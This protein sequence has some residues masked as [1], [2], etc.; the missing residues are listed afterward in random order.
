MPTP[1]KQRTRISLEDKVKLIEDSKRPGFN[2]KDAMEKYGI[3]RNAVSTI[4]KDQAK[5]LKCLDSGSISKTAKSVRKSPLAE[6]ECKLYEFLTEKTRK[7]L[8]INGPLL[9]E[10]AKII[11]ERMKLTSDIPL[12]FEFS[13]GW[14]D[15]FKKRFNVKFKK[16]IGE[17]LSADDEA[18]DEWIKTQ[19]PILRNS[20][21]A[22]DIFNCD[23]CGV[24]FRGMAD[25]SFN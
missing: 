9:T 24:Y 22:K 2:R 20:Y 1:I 3:G 12:E 18:A 17:K 6:L 8:P 10:Q 5:I 15:G 25:K 21:P 4:L 7:G 16:L 19:W 14:L 23:E 13:T 11:H